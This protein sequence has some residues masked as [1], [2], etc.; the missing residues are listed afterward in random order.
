MFGLRYFKFQPS[1]YV[2]R[3]SRGQLVANTLI[4]SS[5]A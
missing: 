3:Y 4:N 1:E 5:S 2:L